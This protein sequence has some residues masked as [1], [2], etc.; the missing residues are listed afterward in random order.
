MYTIVSPRLML[1][2]CAAT[3]ALGLCVT[4]IIVVSQT[5][6]ATSTSS[7]TGMMAFVGSGRDKY[8][9]FVRFVIRSVGVSR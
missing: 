7:G 9:L 4:P 8:L 5:T 2:N 6:S 3:P 1:D